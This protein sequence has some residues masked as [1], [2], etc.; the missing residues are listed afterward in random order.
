MEKVKR[1]LIKRITT[2]SVMLNNEYVDEFEVTKNITYR[3]KPYHSVSFK[4][5]V[6]VQNKIP[7]IN[8][9]VKLVETL[10]KKSKTNIDEYFNFSP[11][12]DMSLSE[13]EIANIIGR[14]DEPAKEYIKANY[15]S[16]LKKTFDNFKLDDDVKYKMV[17]DYFFNTK[18][19]NNIPMFDNDFT[20]LIVSNIYDKMRT[21]KLSITRG[22]LDDLL[23]Q[24]LLFKNTETFGVVYQTATFIANALKCSRHTVGNTLHKLEYIGILKN[25]IGNNSIKTTSMINYMIKTNQIKPVKKNNDDEDQK[26]IDLDKELKLKDQYHNI[27]ILYPVIDFNAMFSYADDSVITEYMDKLKN[28][29]GNIIKNI[30]FRNYVEQLKDKG[31]AKDI[32]KII[33]ENFQYLK[34][35]SKDKVINASQRLDELGKKLVYE[36]DFK[37]QFKKNIK[38]DAMVSY[39]KERKKHFTPTNIV[40]DYYMIGT[41]YKDLIKTFMDGVNVGMDKKGVEF[42]DYKEAM[43][44]GNIDWLMNESLF[45]HYTDLSNEEEYLDKISNVVSDILIKYR[46]SVMNSTKHDNKEKL[47]GINI[48]KAVYNNGDMLR[49]EALKDTKDYKI[50][51]Y[52]KLMSKIMTYNVEHTVPLYDVVYQMW[53]ELKNIQ[54]KKEF[55]IEMYRCFVIGGNDVHFIFGHII[56]F[57]EKFNTIKNI[58][59][60]A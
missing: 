58:S 51:N 2:K 46:E 44:V 32:A 18:I 5:P 27:Y 16:I 54:Q 60:N 14:C 13:S 8:D 41:V 56:D 3:A 38:P 35:Q 19:H 34:P 24:A 11:D 36:Y 28:T 49:I 42:K 12:M 45:K 21:E 29:S 50:L 47:K 4:C 22:I 39:F 53:C 6:V 59:E 17:Y 31:N 55:L 1:P 40:E 52:Y 20:R 30:M 26:G 7:L 43:K 9:K 10:F 57:V 33:I 23:K 25:T 15:K 37:A 48:Y